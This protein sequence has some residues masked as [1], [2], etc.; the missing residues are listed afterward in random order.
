MTAT[1]KR[2][3]PVLF[4]VVVVVTMFGCAKEKSVS[5][6][7]AV[8]PDSAQ[9][10]SDRQS[11][12]QSKTGAFVAEH[13]FGRYTI[14]VVSMSKVIS[15]DAEYKSRCENWN[16][17]EADIV[18]IVRKSKVITGSDVHDLYYR[19]PCVYNVHLNI[20]GIAYS[21]EVNAGSFMYLHN[22]EQSSYLGCS[23]EA[24][25]KYFIETDGDL[26]RDIPTE[27]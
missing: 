2:N 23:D 9:S 26:G 24:C 18:K 4:L 22:A 14:E 25:T 20:N 7:E 16:L 11:I 27:N 13:S 19:L 3:K 8:T 5:S 10:A 12:I 1:M 17:R 21:M 6:G 15:D